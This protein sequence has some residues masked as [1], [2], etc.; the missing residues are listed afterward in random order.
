[1]RMLDASH[2][3]ILADV[4]LLSAFCSLVARTFWV[5]AAELNQVKCLSKKYA[6]VGKKIPCPC[7]ANH[8]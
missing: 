3:L 5:L 7:S 2:V 4:A 6:A 8:W 1:M